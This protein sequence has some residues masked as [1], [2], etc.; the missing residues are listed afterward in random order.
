MGIESCKQLTIRHRLGPGNKGGL[1]GDTVQRDR[2]RN[3]IRPIRP[4]VLWSKR[5][6][7]DRQFAS[8]LNYEKLQDPVRVFSPENNHRPPFPVT[9]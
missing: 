3:N 4:T 1:E 8:H 7:V 5:R 2:K 9:P 6:D